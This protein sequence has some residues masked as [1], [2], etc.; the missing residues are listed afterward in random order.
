VKKKA[1][2]KKTPAR[3]KPAP[4]PKAKVIS[5]K[6]AKLIARQLPALGAPYGGGI[7]GGMC[8]DENDRPYL[9]IMAPRALG[10]FARLQFKTSNTA[11]PGARSWRDGFA[12]SE[13]MND[14]AHPAARACRKLKIN[15]RDDW[16]LPS[17]LEALVMA[18]DFMPDRTTVA[19][20][21]EGGP[22]AFA[23][24]WYWTSTEFNAGCAWVQDFG[25]GTQNAT[26]RTA[27]AAC[28]PSAKNI[29]NPL[30]I[31]RPLRGRGLAF[32]LGE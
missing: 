19:A 21:K 23:R 28:A 1:S 4:K 26:A 5:A 25:Y 12:N 13:A 8:L 22:E 32:Q 6:P 2:V 27:P 7:V 18:D 20:F 11:D 15:G 17:R 31:P 24:D 3:A 30:P 16:T 9:L 29:F 14:K 10:E